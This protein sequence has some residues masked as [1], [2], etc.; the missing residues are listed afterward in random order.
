MVCISVVAFLIVIRCLSAMV[1]WTEIA[2]RRGPCVRRA[3]QIS[4]G[5]TWTKNATLIVS[6][7]MADQSHRNIDMTAAVFYSVYNTYCISEIHLFEVLLTYK[8][9]K[10]I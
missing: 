6:L 2:E 10:K 4:H 3:R 9:K 7:Q 1:S 8:T 5:I